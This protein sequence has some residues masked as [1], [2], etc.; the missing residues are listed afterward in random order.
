MSSLS[1]TQP[2][3]AGS[4]WRAAAALGL[5]TCGALLLQERRH[6]AGQRA[7]LLP[8]CA[9]LHRQAAGALLQCLQQLQVAAGRRT[10]AAAAARA[11]PHGLLVVS[12]R[13]CWPRPVARWQ[14][15]QCSAVQAPGDKQNCLGICM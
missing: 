2:P 6:L 8:Q 9:I 11:G 12:V 3:P 1:S 7:Q 15:Q 14:R 13:G 4:A 5:P 10:V